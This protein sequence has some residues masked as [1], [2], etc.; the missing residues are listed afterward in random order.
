MLGLMTLGHFLKDASGISGA[1]STFE[2]VYRFMVGNTLA[3]MI[4]YLVAQTVDVHLFHFWKRL[5]KGKH[6]WL[7]NNLSTTF[8][9]L[10]DT[11][12]ILSILYF[13]NNLGDQ[14]NSL[15]VLFSLIV[16]SYLF[17][18]FFALFDTPLFYLGVWL[19]KDK[20]HEDPD[21]KSWGYRGFKKEAL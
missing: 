4:A 20:V 6:L 13:A 5:T 18:F 1:A 12:A 7:R 3:S 9:Q 8:S 21:E 10:V 16:S 15:G 19:L 14:V 11:T 17:K 2:D